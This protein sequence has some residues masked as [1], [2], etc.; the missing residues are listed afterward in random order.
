MELDMEITL[1]IIAVGNGMAGK[2][3]LLTRYAKGVMTDGY[4]K[5]IGTDFMERDVTT[6][7]GENIRLLL[8]DTAG[9][10]SINICKKHHP[11]PFFY[12]C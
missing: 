11:N 3:S 12:H 10:Y 7:S 5:T 6:K 9:Q 2:T 4:K 1:K 8:W